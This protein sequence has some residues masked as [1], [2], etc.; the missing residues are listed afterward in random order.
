MKDFEFDCDPQNGRKFQ[1]FYTL[2]VD[3]DGDGIPAAVGPTEICTGNLVIENNLYYTPGYE[4]F[5]MAIDWKTMQEK[6]F[7]HSRLGSMVNSKDGV[8]RTNSRILGDLGYQ[9]WSL[10][11]R[12]IKGGGQW[13]YADGRYD[14][15]GLVDCDD[16]DAAVPYLGVYLDSDGDGA[17]DAGQY[18]SCYSPLVNK[19][20]WITRG[21][22]IVSNGVLQS[23][24]D[25][26][27]AFDCAPLDP[28]TLGEM[29]LYVD[30]DG[31]GHGTGDPTSMCLTASMT[32]KPDGVPVGYSKSGDDCNDNNPSI[33]EYCDSCPPGKTR[34]P[35]TQTCEGTPLVDENPSSA[36]PVNPSSSPEPTNSCG[37]GNASS[38]QYGSVLDCRDRTVGQE[39][40]I[41]GTAL[42][43]AYS[44]SNQKSQAK[45]SRQTSITIGKYSNRSYGDLK[46]IKVT[47]ALAGRSFEQVYFI[48]SIDG[49]TVPIDYTF[50]WDGKDS[51]G[52]EIN[53]IVPAT[54]T[55]DYMFAG[56]SYP[57]NVRRVLP[58]RFGYFD[59]A[60][61]NLGGWSFSNYHY[62]DK[63]SATVFMGNGQRFSS[64]DPSK[65]L[66]QTPDSSG[67][68]SI[69]SSDASILFQFDADGH[70]IATKDIVTGVVLWKFNHDENRMLQEVV[71]RN[72]LKTSL[73]RNSEKFLVAI[74][75]P[76]GLVTNVTTDSSGYITELTNPG[77]HV[78]KF[79]YGSEAATGLMLTMELPGSQIKTYTYDD[80]G[81]LSA[82]TDAMGNTRT[83]GQTLSVDGK[84]V[85]TTLTSA[86]G[87]VT[88]YET[89]AAPSNQDTKTTSNIYAS[90]LANTVISGST[91][92]QQTWNDGTSQK[93]YSAVNELYPE[94]FSPTTQEIDLLSNSSQDNTRIDITRQYGLNDPNDPSSISSYTETKS[95][96]GLGTYI[97]TFDRATM[98]ATNVSP[99]GLTTKRLYDSAGNLVSEQFGNLL[100]TT[101]T[102]NDQ[103]QPIRIT[104][105]NR[106]S[107]LNY[108]LKGNLANVRDPLGNITR[109]AY[110]TRGMVSAVTLPNGD[111]HK[112]AYDP[113]DLDQKAYF[114]PNLSRF[115]YGSN[116]NDLPVSFI[117]PTIDSSDY[118]WRWSYNAD[119]QA[120]RYI[121]PNGTALVRTYGDHGLVSKLRGPGI[122]RDYQYANGLLTSISWSPMDK[123]SF[124]GSQQLMT[125][126]ISEGV[127]IGRVDYIHGT[128]GRL[129]GILVNGV[130][131]SF[132][133]SA[134]GLLTAAG[135]LAISRTPDTGA[136]ASANDGLTQL[137]FTYNLYGEVTRRKYVL[138]PRYNYTL[139]YLRDKLGRVSSVTTVDR[140]TTSAVQYTYDSIGRLAS[141]SDGTNVSNYSYSSTGNRL[142]EGGQEVYD[143][144]NR[145]MSD[146]TWNYTYDRNG[147]LTRK[148]SKING[149]SIDYNYDIMGNLLSVSNSEN[150]S[151][152][153][154]TADGLN[155]RLTKKVNGEFKYALLYQD[156][157]RPVAMLDQWNTVRATFVYGTLSNSP[158]L[159]ILDG[160]TYRFIHDH[161]GSPLFVVNTGTGEIVQAMK[162]DSW[163]KVLLDTN[164]GFQPFGYAGGLYDP[165]TGLV[166]FG[167][168][169]YDPSI[170]RWLN[171]DPIR[172]E[173]GWNLYAY[174]GNDPVNFIDPK[175]TDAQVVIIKGFHSGIQVDSP[176][177][178]EPEI[179]E[180]GP[181]DIIPTILAI[182]N[183][184]VPS[185]IKIRPLSE[186][187]GV[188]GTVPFTRIP[189]DRQSTIDFLK[190]MRGIADYN[191]AT[192]GWDIPYQLG[193]PGGMNCHHFTG[194]VMGT[195]GK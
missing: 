40:P 41:I 80:L 188:I 15:P 46:Y 170:G 105:G 122:T 137:S 86:L 17:P 44:S 19:N 76:F 152:V 26:Q 108:N 136:I 75:S 115:A 109:Y 37:S 71:D 163:G 70:H 2:G 59:Q 11:W 151:L 150:N 43:L 63:A 14:V 47:V 195:L 181:K 130:G 117:E 169:D 30:A 49:V 161:L 187:K 31:D 154:Y 69:P 182:P 10:D 177:G 145:L 60:S 160:V 162:Y 138:G 159:M 53:G 168:R 103:G 124:T 94:V 116:K 180:F 48:N 56:Y 3:V 101:Y 140:G 58:M 68:I 55:F 133:Y 126:A 167:A 149:K 147:F 66:N 98:S 121:T 51:A 54:L 1:K 189:L 97:S 171:K 178:G 119:N 79:A 114:D 158:D 42:S 8:Y 134:D 33:Y 141:V 4:R 194:A 82:T 16:N 190:T 95:I 118:R 191:R 91:S 111:R 62:Y 144:Q 113:S 67:I 132:D 28:A 106:V 192:G 112:F 128:M 156:A 84:K 96:T 85:T 45:R 90:G 88:T 73:T 135:S 83:I 34:D 102:Y 92:W 27:L 193:G 13:G 6:L 29:T 175:G 120:L 81:R 174:V 173:G 77:N 183:L 99:S 176:Y 32:L 123:I 143:V 65:T 72:G 74:T 184:P 38:L 12:R 165:E 20:S 23:P 153:E 5:G 186:V 164:P 18:L 100:P 110:N 127:V 25:R 9:Y 39:I 35:V 146:A 52:V 107:V 125:S 157:L 7:E 87:R 57:I 185:E 93:T 21:I 129:Q 142:T 179:I 139:T 155:R 64:R 36:P 148:D 131:I 89:E 24:V 61:L 166:R 78:T 172:L 50:E 104:Q 22:A